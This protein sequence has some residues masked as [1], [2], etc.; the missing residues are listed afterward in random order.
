MEVS[1]VSEGEQ[2]LTIRTFGS[3]N[4]QYQDCKRTVLS[5]VQKNGQTRSLKLL[6]DLLI[7]EPVTCQTVSLCLD[8]F[9]YIAQLDLADPL[10]GS[11]GHRDQYWNLVTGETRWN[12]GPLDLN[13]ELG[14]ILY[15][16]VASPVWDTPSN[17]SSPTLYVSM[18]RLMTTCKS[19]MT[20]SNLSGC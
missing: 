6:V 17:A 18:A 19:W 9:D 2:P 16:P 12:Y 3:N 5:V 1:L 11:P 7:C 10:D 14:W 20:D 13:I 8:T 15:G 4:E